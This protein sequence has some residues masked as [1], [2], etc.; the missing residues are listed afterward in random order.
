MSKSFGLKM[1]RFAICLCMAVLMGYVVF[2]IL[3]S[4]KLG[5]FIPVEGAYL[6]AFVNVMFGGFFAWRLTSDKPKQKSLEV[7]Y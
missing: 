7:K 2:T 1:F 4:E 6:A 3:T 5:G